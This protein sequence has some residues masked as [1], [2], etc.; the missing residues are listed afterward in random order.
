M[1]ATLLQVTC[2]NKPL[3]VEL[4]R[5]IHY[6]L[7]GQ[8]FI[9]G[10]TDRL[11]KIEMSEKKEELRNLLASQGLRATAP[12]LGVLEVLAD[13]E[14]PLSHSEVVN[15]IGDMDWD[16]ATIYRNLVK[17]R[18]ADIAPVVSRLDGIDRYA[19]KTRPGEVH[20]HPH[21]ACYICGELTCLP[22]NLTNLNALEGAWAKAVEQ[23][24][25]QLRG[26]CPKCA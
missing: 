24:S 21:F 16:P 19:L 15:R 22:S 9:H 23:A 4:S 17:L 26:L 18:D 3:P 25:V 7:G 1:N 8:R 2:I 14:R 11:G 5:Q 12:R 20:Q 13:A 6:S 10:L